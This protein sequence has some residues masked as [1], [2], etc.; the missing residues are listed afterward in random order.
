MNVNYGSNRRA[1]VSSPLRHFGLWFA[2]VGFLA[3]AFASPLASAQ[4]RQSSTDAGDTTGLIDVT[5]GGLLRQ[6]V[7]ADWLSYNGDYTGRRY[8][9]L[10]Q[11]TP[12]NVS[13]LTVQWVFHPR[14]VSPLEVTPVVDAGV[15]FVTS[16]ND[17]YALDAAT[18]KQLWHH[19]RT[20]TE[21]L[22]DDAS[23]HHNR[24]VAILGTRIYMETDNAHLLC[25]DAR[26]GSLIWD[27]AYAT[28]NNNYGA[29][30]AP[31]GREE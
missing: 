24:G 7:G 21:G 1:P 8:S 17:A 2:S 30:S 23:V 10:T 28:G 15:M 29:T 11:I 25:L 22:V 20:L 13:H 26:S 16:A 27:A 9:G 18:G 12:A 19:S 4:T 5:E 14:E 6:P 3:L 31:L